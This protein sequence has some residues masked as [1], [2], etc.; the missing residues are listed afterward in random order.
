MGYSFKGGLGNFPK[1]KF[2]YSK[3]CWKKIE[4][5]LSTFHV[6][7]L[8]EVR[9]NFISQNSPSLKKEWSVL[10]SPTSKTPWSAKKTNLPA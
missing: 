6:L 10:N 4:Q 3:T 1:K 8:I 2:M 7:C 9:N 5:V